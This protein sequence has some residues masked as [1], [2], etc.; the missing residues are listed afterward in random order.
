LQALNNLI[1]KL[2][3]MDLVTQV[4][5]ETPGIAFGFAFIFKIIFSLLLILYI[6]YSFFLALRVRILADT[7]RTPSNNSLRKLAFFHLY[8]VII[9]GSI[10]L[11]FIIIA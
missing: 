10:A 1:V 11:F 2:I 6:A 4:G 7:V 8:A 3:A 5:V 9:V